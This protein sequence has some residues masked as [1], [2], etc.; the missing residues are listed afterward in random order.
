M[1]EYADVV[2]LAETI[3]YLEKLAVAAHYLATPG[4]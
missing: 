2:S 4:R 1:H 3:E